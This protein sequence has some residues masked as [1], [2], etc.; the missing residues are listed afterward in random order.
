MSIAL[1]IHSSQGPAS[2]KAWDL[3]MPADPGLDAGS[4]AQPM[5]FPWAPL[6]PGVWLAFGIM[7]SDLLSFAKA[8]RSSS[9]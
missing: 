5:C 4:A 3:V 2:R 9:P 1:I 7:S 6:W 8:L